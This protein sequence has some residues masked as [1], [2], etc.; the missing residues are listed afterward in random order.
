M[1]FCL[2]DSPAATE[3]ANIFRD[4]VMLQRAEYS[5]KNIQSSGRRDGVRLEDASSPG[6]PLRGA[7]WS[8]SFHLMPAR[9]A[10]K[11]ADFQTLEW[12]RR[13]SNYMGFAVTLAT[14]NQRNKLRSPYK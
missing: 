3:S 6:G 13:P 2:L 1:L 5:L 14:A 8:D 10:L 7:T 11:G 12:I 4:D 9:A